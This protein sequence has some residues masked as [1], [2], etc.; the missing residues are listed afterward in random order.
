MPAADPVADPAL[1]SATEPLLSGLGLEVFLAS[2]FDLRSQLAAFLAIQPEELEARM[3]RSTDA[4]AA[5]HPGGFSPERAS[6]FYED[7]VGDGHLLEL[8]AWH[9]GSAD[10][11]ADTLRLQQ[12]F[13]RGQVLDF[14]GGIGTH[15]LAAAALPAVDRVC[16]VDLNPRN[17][18]FVQWRAERMGLAD[19]LLCCRDLEDSRLPP[20]FDTI[21]C[22]DVLEHLPDPAGQLDCFAARMSPEA[23]ALLNWYF[24]RGFDGEYPFHFDDPALVEAFFRRLQG[25]FLEVFHPYLITT[26]A[27]RLLPAA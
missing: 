27:Y 7:T 4:L 10:Y 11:I 20:Q 6:A 19:R 14:G 22:L 2:G 25:R 24:F 9:L 17:R 12:R 26:R 18:A 3:P 1:R 16:V 21:V 15:A 13:A 23:I 5:L 8:A